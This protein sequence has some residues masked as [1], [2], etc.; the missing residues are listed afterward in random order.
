MSNFLWVGHYPDC[1]KFTDFDGS[2]LFNL[3][4][5]TN[6]EYDAEKQIL[7]MTTNINGQIHYECQTIPNCCAQ[8][9]LKN[10]FE[11]TQTSNNVQNQ[12]NALWFAPPGYQA[13]RQAFEQDRQESL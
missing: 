3:K 11:K 8:K 4:I 9:I 10:L 1:E 5:V 12:V 2:L 13:A 7:N 6:A